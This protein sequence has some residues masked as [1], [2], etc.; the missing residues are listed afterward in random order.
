MKDTIFASI[1]PDA[2]TD[3]EPQHTKFLKV[4][5]FSAF[6]MLQYSKELTSRSACNECEY[7]S[8]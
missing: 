6:N 5:L 3:K 8:K 2:H 1:Y 4:H 7:A